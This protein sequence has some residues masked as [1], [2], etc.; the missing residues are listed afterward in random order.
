MQNK[1]S[2]DEE[3][4]MKALSRLSRDQLFQLYSIIIGMITYNKNK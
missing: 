1:D 4:I 2:L 3:I